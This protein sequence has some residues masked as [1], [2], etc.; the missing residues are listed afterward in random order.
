MRRLDSFAA[1]KCRTEPS[2]CA[3]REKSPKKTTSPY[4]NSE[5]IRKETRT[6]RRPQQERDNEIDR[7]CSQTAGAAGALLDPS[8]VGPAMKC[9][10]IQQSPQAHVATYVRISSFLRAAGRDGRPCSSRAQIRQKEVVVSPTK[11]VST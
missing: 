2:F 8:L 10:V 5:R 9:C 3:L 11:N 7:A 1:E 4:N 6:Q